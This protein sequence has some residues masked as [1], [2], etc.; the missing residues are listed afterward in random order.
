MNKAKSR[1][2]KAGMLVRAGLTVKNIATTGFE[3]LDGKG[4]PVWSFFT[5]RVSLATLM[6]NLILAQGSRWVYGMPHALSVY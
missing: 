1:W 5:L 6:F 4:L 2:K 3:V